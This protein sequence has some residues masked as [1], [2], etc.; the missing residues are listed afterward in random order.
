MTRIVRDQ[1]QGGRREIK[2]NGS[3]PRRVKTDEDDGDGVDDDDGSYQISPG[4]ASQATNPIGSTGFRKRRVI[5][6]MSGIHHYYYFLSP[7]CFS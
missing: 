4:L 1:G 2:G 3:D 6:I 7:L 5:K